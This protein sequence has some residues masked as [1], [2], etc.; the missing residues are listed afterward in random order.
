MRIVMSLTTAGL[1][2]AASIVPAFASENLSGDELKQAVSGKGVFLATPFGGEFPLNYRA[3]GVVDGSGKAV[4]LGKY[5]AP[6]DS[7]RWWVDGE[8]LCQKWKSW[9]DGKQF[10]FTVQ[11]LGPAKI[12]WVRD[13]GMSGT[14]RIA[15]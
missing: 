3:N 9:Y 11:S 2:A 6:T 15:D 4:G 14:A 1:L 5:M 10:C 7:G 8:K 13:D 12:S